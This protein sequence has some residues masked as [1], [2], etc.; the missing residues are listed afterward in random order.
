[1]LKNVLKRLISWHWE[2]Q[3][4]LEARKGTEDGKY[5]EV[6]CSNEIYGTKPLSVFYNTKG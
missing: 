6:T 5:R 4:T 3:C 1:M 2:V